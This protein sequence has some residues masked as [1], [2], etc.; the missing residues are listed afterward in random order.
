VSPISSVA[1]S[2]N[3]RLPWRTTVPSKRIEVKAENLTATGVIVG[4]PSYMAPEQVL[5]S[6]DE[7]SD[8][9]GAGAILYE[10]A[11]GRPPFVGETTPEILT[12]LVMAEPIWPRRL[13]PGIPPDLEAIILRC[14]EKDRTRRH[15]S[16][17][18]LA[19]DPDAFLAGQPLRHARRPTFGYVL[20][21]RIRKQPLL[22]AFGTALVLAV[23]GGW[24]N[25]GRTPEDG[26]S[27]GACATSGGNGGGPSR[28]ST[29]RWRSIRDIATRFS[30]RRGFSSSW[31][32]SAR[33]SPTAGAPG[34]SA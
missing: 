23:A 22:W 28:R 33:R 13:N 31:R 12:Q 5:G 21:K 24:T 7:L 32:S 29:A 25:S 1:P 4:T 2:R 3:T 30:P 20:A 16:A 9:Y 27:S 14:L 17:D 6:A 34:T 26:G 18:A 10:L 11:A 15:R 8:L 19:E